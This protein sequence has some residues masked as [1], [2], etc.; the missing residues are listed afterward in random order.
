M[1]RRIVTPDKKSIKDEN[2]I[3]TSVTVPT[4][5]P[6]SSEMPPSDISLDDIHERLKLVLFRE[7]KRL[8]EVSAAR[9]LGKE[10]GIAF[11][12]CVKVS[13][14]FKKEEREIIELEERLKKDETDI[15]DSETTS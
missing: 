11:E 4:P 1:T 13:R 6:S 5:S 8:T 14:E 7:T 10:E 2:G 9:L 3:Y 15:E 12:R